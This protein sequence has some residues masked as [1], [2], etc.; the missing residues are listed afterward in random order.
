MKAATITDVALRAGVS[1]ATVS[2]FV[3]RQQRFSPDVEERIRTAVAALGY[4][5]NPAARSIA[6]GVTG[7]IGLAA[8]DVCNLHHAM[9][10]KGA[11]AAA[12]ARGYSLLV[13][14]I[15]DHPDQEGILGALATRVDGMVVSSRIPDAI[16]DWL[17]DIGKPVVYVGW[18]P[19]E[20]IVS[21]RTD[22]HLAATILGSHL[23]RQGARRIAYLG[24]PR[25]AWNAERLRGLS[26][27]AEAAGGSVTEFAV[28]GLTVDAGE[29]VASRVLL[30]AER[31]DAIVGCNDRV[32]IGILMEA[33]AM[34][35][36]VPG[37][38]SVAGFDNIEPSR[39]VGL[40]TM[41]MGSQQNGERAARNII[42]RIRNTAGDDTEVQPFLVARA[43]TG[44]LGGI[45]RPEAEAG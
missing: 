41:D 27:A 20:G 43:S 12:L 30:G 8:L 23:V 34:G 14:D 9:V 21:I 36:S 40:T 38:L 42:D 28:D 22:S 24:I 17:T 13:V 1:I 18:P 11:N 35:F 44:P 39:Y 33:R 31:F 16:V 2:K 32:A 5:G 10:I 7:A 26:E 6:T 15:E 25:L 3:N 37:D 19:K 4:R 45:A 29:K